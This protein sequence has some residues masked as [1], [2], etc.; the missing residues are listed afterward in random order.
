MDL[1]IQKAY[2]SK[3]TAIVDFIH[4]LFTFIWRRRPLVCQ[5]CAL[6][7]LFRVGDGLLA[8]EGRYADRGIDPLARPP[9]PNARGKELPEDPP[10]Q[11]VSTTLRYLENTGHG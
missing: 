7:Y 9:G 4:V 6:G 1:V 5:P 2:F 3:Y 11:V 8:G 10:R